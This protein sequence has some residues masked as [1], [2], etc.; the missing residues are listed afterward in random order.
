MKNSKIRNSILTL[1]SFGI[2][3]FFFLYISLNFNKYEHLFR[4]SIPHISALLLF[5]VLFKYINGLVNT[6]LYQIL[7]APIPISDGFWLSAVATLAN[8]LP[9]SGGIISKGIYL[10]QVHKLSYTRFLSATLAL[11]FMFVSANG[12]IGLF[13]IF[14]WQIAQG[15]TTPLPLTLGFAGMAASL[16]VFLLPIE[17]MRKINLIGNRIEKTLDGWKII[18]QTPR[19]VIRLTALQ[20]GLVLLLAI[21]YWVSFQ[22]VSQKITFGQT[23]LF[24]SASVLTQIVSIAPGGLGVREGIVAAVAGALGFDIGIVIIAVGIERLISTFVT[25]VF[26]VIGINVLG[27]RL[28]AS[29]K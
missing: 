20:T 14:Y 8:L 29:P 7:G 5:I 26:G 15:F 17:R 2:I 11:F 10:K 1:L 28:T 12:I 25:I 27:T 23:I 9:I 21:R 6:A 4:L 24:S 16:I 13:I 22:M 18:K 19:A 3:V